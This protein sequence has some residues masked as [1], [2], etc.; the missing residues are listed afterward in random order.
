MGAMFFFFGSGI[1]LYVHVTYIIAKNRVLLSTAQS[2]V[3]ED[4]HKSINL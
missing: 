3:E 2:S 1:E 4:M